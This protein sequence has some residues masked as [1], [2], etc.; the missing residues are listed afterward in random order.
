MLRLWNTASRS[1]EEFSPLRPPHVGL[2]TCGPTVYWDAHIGNMRAYLF[3]DILQRTLEIEGY[4]VRRVINITDVGHLTTDEDEGEDKIEVAAKKEGRSAQEVAER[5]T[6]RFLDDARKLNIK[7]PPAPYLCK[8]TEHIKEQV[9]LIR[10]LEKKGFTYAT[11]DGI[12]FDTSKFPAYGKLGGQNLAEKEEGARIGMNIEKRNK[13]DF[14][15]WK[16]SVKKSPPY[17][18]GDEGGV[19]KRQQEWPSPWG[20]GFPG[21]HIECSAMSRKYLGQPFDIHCG[22]VDH[23]PV[24]HENEIA[25]SEAAYG[26]PLARYWLHSEFLLV[27]HQKMSKSL[28]NV[29]TLAD[30]TVRGVDPLALRYLY[31]GTHYRQKQNF[32]WEA[33]GAAQNALSRLRWIIRDYDPPDIGC[34]EYEAEFTSALEDDLN[35]PVAL[36]VLWKLV[37]DLRYPSKVKSASL[38]WM[39]QVLGLSLE[40]LIG[41]PFEVPEDVR[42]LISRREVARK[43]QDWKTA[44]ALRREIEE[45]GWMLEDATNGTKTFPIK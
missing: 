11:S 18:G 17:E 7:L 16:F 22:G 3:E 14:A 25:Q 44:D 43:A 13:T 29:H 12:Y 42:L 41:K 35:T 2:Y 27:E 24:H 30:V 19:S 31:L 40:E 1:L 21:W 10:E 9:D 8:A 36:S 15:L 38:V 5:Y 28:G 6:Q 23:I 32:T 45:K 4:E 26:A 20:V 37:D 39:D 34:A 33:L